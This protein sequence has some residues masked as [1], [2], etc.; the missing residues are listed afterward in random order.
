MNV[1]DFILYKNDISP[2]KKIMIDMVPFLIKIISYFNI[3]SI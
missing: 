3:N 2:R 1:Y